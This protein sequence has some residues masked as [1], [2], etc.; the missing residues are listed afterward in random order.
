MGV[1]PFLEVPTLQRQHLATRQA[2]TFVALTLYRYDMRL[3]HPRGSAEGLQAASEKSAQGDLSD[4]SRERVRG[5][6]PAC[7]TKKLRSDVLPPFGDH[8]TQVT[9]SRRMNN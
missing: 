6:I 8:Q 7:N 4:S 9:V 1:F 5:T 2:L 3:L